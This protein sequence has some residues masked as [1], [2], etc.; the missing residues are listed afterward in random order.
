MNLKNSRLKEIIF[1][2]PNV[3]KKFPNFTYLCGISRWGRSILPVSIIV[4]PLKLYHFCMW[5]RCQRFHIKKKLLLRCKN[6]VVALVNPPFMQRTHVWGHFPPERVCVVFGL[7]LV[8]ASDHFDPILLRWNHSNLNLIPTTCVVLI[9]QCP[10]EFG[11][12]SMFCQDFITNSKSLNKIKMKKDENA[13]S[14][15]TRT[16]SPWN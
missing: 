6:V 2:I 8:I 5:V 12:T 15:Q 13:G 16:L 10:R 4:T 1:S 9:R 3:F 11:I 14:Y 7:K